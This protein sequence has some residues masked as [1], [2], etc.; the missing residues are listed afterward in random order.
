MPKRLS[1][2]GCT[3]SARRHT[4]RQT[5]VGNVP[6]TDRAAVRVFDLF[7]KQPR[8]YRES[9][10]HETNYEWFGLDLKGIVILQGSECIWSFWGGRDA[11]SA[12]LA[13]YPVCFKHDN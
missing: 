4:P 13:V 7:D 2:H 9:V 8:E 5:T 10:F 3:C 1:V 6:N 12:V 11:R